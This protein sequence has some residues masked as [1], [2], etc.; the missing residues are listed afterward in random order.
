MDRHRRAECF[1]HRFVADHAQFWK[2]SFDVFNVIELAENVSGQV[3][4]AQGRRFFAVDYLLV[5]G[6]AGQVKYADGQ[7]GFIHPVHSVG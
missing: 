3:H 7:A 5:S 2:R 1:F 4:M 6:K